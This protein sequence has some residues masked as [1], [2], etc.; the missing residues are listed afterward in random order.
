MKLVGPL[1]RVINYKYTSETKS[2]ILDILYQ[3]HLNFP[4]IKPFAPQLQTTYFKLLAEFELG[5][6][7]LSKITDNFIEL[8]KIS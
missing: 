1:I 3:I 5:K 4:Q 2:M 6:D 7:F 8:V